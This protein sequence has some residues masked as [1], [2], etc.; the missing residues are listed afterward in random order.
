M[1]YNYYTLDSNSNSTYGQ[2]EDL[3]DFIDSWMLRKG[4]IIEDEY[5]KDAH[6]Q[7][8][9]TEGN[10]LTDYV[11]NIYGA[12]M[13]SQKLKDL[14]DSFDIDE[15]VVQYLPFKLSDKKGR[16]FDGTFYIVNPL[17]SVECL[18]I[19]QI[20][21]AAKNSKYYHDTPKIFHYSGIQYTSDAREKVLNLSF[22]IVDKDK[23]PDDKLIF[24]I[25]EIP[26]HIIIRNDVMQKILDSGLTG[27]PF[28]TASTLEFKS[29]Q[30]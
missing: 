16:P 8:H 14:L 25:K 30:L 3:T 20:A 13:I 12:F 28:R 2:V 5:P 27:M 24:R 18:D 9:K 15:T 21:V 1:S 10:L 6:F 11:N 29:Y 19:D 7:F 4:R 23:I 26:D 22:I 17:E